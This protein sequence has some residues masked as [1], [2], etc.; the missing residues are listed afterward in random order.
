MS[1]PTV[2]GGALL[3][4]EALGFLGRRPN[5]GFAIAPA[6]L[7]SGGALPRRDDALYELIAR[8]RLAG[9]LPD[10][11]SETE[12]ARRYQVP[13]HRLSRRP[14]RDRRGPARASGRE[15]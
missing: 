15:V 9:T 4:L 1:G 2:T 3:Q 8:D 7:A 13:R 5:R 6:A 14:R 11:V 12:L 10:H